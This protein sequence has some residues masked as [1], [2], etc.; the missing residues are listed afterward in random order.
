MLWLFWAWQ[1]P[2]LFNIFISFSNKEPCLIRFGFYLYISP[3]F[4][5][6]RPVRARWLGVFRYKQ[7][8]C[9]L[10]HPYLTKFEVNRNKIT[11]SVD[12]FL[13]SFNYQKFLFKKIIY[14]L[15]SFFTTFLSNEE[16]LWY[17]EL[18]VSPLH[19]RQGRFF[20]WWHPNPRGL[21]VT[22]RGA[23]APMP[24]ICHEL[25][26]PLQHTMTSITIMLGSFLPPPYSSKWNK[27][28]NTK[29]CWT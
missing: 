9:L 14:P 7:G 25:F 16:V 6:S 5:Q 20:P 4:L 24:Y 26:L 18:Q 27:A 23:Q 3:G 17:T 10:N 11:N 28:I 2:V 13:Y 12:F 19:R 8:T 1:H 22:P 21:L 29:T 15:Y